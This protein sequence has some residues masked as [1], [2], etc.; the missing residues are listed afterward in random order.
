[1]TFKISEPSI[2][3]ADGIVKA[4]AASWRATYASP[5]NGVSKEF[6][7][8]VA[9]GLS[10]NYIKDRLE[11]YLNNPNILYL[12][13]KGRDG[14]VMG[15]LH[16]DKTKETNYLDAIYLPPDFTGKGIGTALMDKYFAWIDKSKPCK[17]EVASYNQGAIKFYEKYGFKITN[18]ELPK[19]KGVMPIIEMVRPA[20]S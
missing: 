4:Q 19:L 6:V 17:L 16:A 18:K 2:G 15:F 13:A 12:V 14:N 5:E 8:S 1:M 10:A 9:E 20:E 11:D 7:D 3:D